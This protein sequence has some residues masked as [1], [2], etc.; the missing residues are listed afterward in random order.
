MRIGDV[1]R[2]TGLK[3]K[4]IRLYEEKGLL[5]V[6]RA[7]NSYREYD[8]TIVAK[9]KIIAL[10][11]RAGIPLMDIQLW[12]DGVIPADE[13]LHKRLSA[14]KNNADQTAGQERL[15]M[16]LMEYI[17]DSFMSIPAELLSVDNDADVDNAGAETEVLSFTDQPCCVGIDIGTTTVCAYVLRLSDGVPVGIYNIRNSSDL[18]SHFQGDKRQDVEVLY[19]R[20]LR[21]IDALLHRYPTICSIGFTGQMHGILCMDDKCNALTPLFTWQDQRAGIGQPCAVDEIF[22]KT[23]HHISAGY[24][25]ATFY[26]LLREKNVPHATT[27]I[28]TIMDFIASKLCGVGVEFMHTT[29]AASL[30]LYDFSGCFDTEALRALGISSTLLP[31]VVDTPIVIGTYGS[32]PVIIPIG[33]NQASFFGAVKDLHTTVL[34]NFGT[35]SQ[36]SL[37]STGDINE[38]DGNSVETRPFPGGGCLLSGSALCGGRAYAML[39]QFFRAFVIAAGGEDK[40]QYAVLN[41]LASK[42]MDTEDKSDR[43]WVK[44]T[45]CGTRDHPDETGAIFGIKEGTFTP[46]ALAVGVLRGMAEELYSMYEKMPHR[47]ITQLVVSGNAIRR[48]PVL[49][50]VLSEV[51]GMP[52]LIP[53]EQ[54]EAAFGAAMFAALGAGCVKNAQE[55]SGWIRYRN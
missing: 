55:L 13:M 20:V 36:I 4:T 46:G 15:C 27:R 42:E 6:D 37:F 47:H 35:G 41:C 10:L 22:E 23:G 8:D 43:L 5:S 49:C 45:F 7:E 39:E 44:T 3:R 14:L 30:G 24:G 11:R 53:A 33:D 2:L 29:N 28:C 26:A 9:L 31:K 32:V 50:R 48:N 54:E 40:E 1:E 51:F 34:A 12:Q 19:N 21:L 25:L 16:T 52:V 18:Q 38:Q 17:E